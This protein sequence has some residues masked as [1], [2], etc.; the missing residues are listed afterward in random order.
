MTQHEYEG[1]MKCDACTKT[2]QKS[3][4]VC[5]TK[6]KALDSISTIALLAYVVQ[7]L[8]KE[9]EKEAADTVHT[10]AGDVYTFE[11]LDVADG[12]VERSCEQAGK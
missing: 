9:G 3:C 6:V 2:L 1:D 12:A 11:C 8:Y 5:K 10:V 7:R 4:K